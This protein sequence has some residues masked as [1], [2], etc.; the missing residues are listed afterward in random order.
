M[1]ADTTI[2]VLDAPAAQAITEQQPQGIERTM[3]A[4]DRLPVVLAIVLIV[5]A[6]ILLLLIRT[7]RRLSRLER[8]LDSMETREPHTRSTV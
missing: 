7:E 4:E 6:G 8:S 5:W 2:A 3:L 1:Q